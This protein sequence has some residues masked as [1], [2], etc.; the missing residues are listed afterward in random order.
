[1]MKMK[2]N[3]CHYDGCHYGRSPRAWSYQQIFSDL[4]NFQ[5]KPENFKTTIF[6]GKARKLSS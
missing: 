2:G 4:R 3:G 1:M 5:K 6:V